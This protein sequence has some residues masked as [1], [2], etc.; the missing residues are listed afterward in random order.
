MRWILGVAV[1]ALAAC[2]DEPTP[3][4]KA[5]EDARAIAEVEA[6]QEAPPEALSPSPIRYAEIEKYGLYG[7]GC[8]FAPEGGGLGAV[9]LAMGDKGYMMRESEL[10]IFAPD[11]GSDE[12]PYLARRKYDGKDHSFTLDLDEGSAKKTGMETTDYKGQ[13]IVRDGKDRVVYQAKGLV[14]CGA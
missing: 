11:M 2:N 14:Q 13:L 12:L 4:E 5:A 7:A 3:Q 1:L 9:A 6:N 10:L 8:S